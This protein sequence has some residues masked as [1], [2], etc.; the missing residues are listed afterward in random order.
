MNDSRHLYYKQTPDTEINELFS[1]ELAFCAPIYSAIVG[2]WE[3]MS[4][5]ARGPEDLPL[6]RIAGRRLARG[7]TQRLTP[8]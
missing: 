1:E 4:H 7:L 6:A 8:E 3:M 5:P 2:G